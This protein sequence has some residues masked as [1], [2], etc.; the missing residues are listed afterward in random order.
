MHGVS[1][2]FLCLLL[3][4]SWCCFYYFF[5]SLPGLICVVLSDSFSCSWPEAEANWNSF[6]FCYISFFFFFL[7]SSREKQ[8]EE[9]GK[10]K[11]KERKRKQS[12]ITIQRNDQVCMG[13]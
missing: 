13:W 7:P 4:L 2:L 6:L 8:G 1:M 12:V 10:K 9:K 5:P 3:Q 11:K